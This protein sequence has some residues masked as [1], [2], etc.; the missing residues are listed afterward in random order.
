MSSPADSFFDIWFTITFT[1]VFIGTLVL[2]VFVPINVWPGSIIYPK[3][4][5]V[6]VL[7]CEIV[8]IPINGLWS[9]LINGAIY[10]ALGTI[11]HLVVRLI[12]RKKKK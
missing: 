4:E 3:Y 12:K 10:G 7:T 1:I 5:V 8:E 6:C 9:G 2:T 11:G